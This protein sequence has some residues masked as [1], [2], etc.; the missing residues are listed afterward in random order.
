MRVTLALAAVACAASAAHLDARDVVRAKTRT[1]RAPWRG[2]D[3][4]A[5][6][7]VLNGHLKQMFPRT[8]P[9]HE[10]SA[11]EL[12]EFQAQLY[13]TRHE[14]LDGIYS[15]V[16]DNRR[17]RLPSLESYRQTWR[18]L[19][20]EVKRQP[21]LRDMHRD[22]HCHEAVMWL[23]HHVP[24]AEQQTRFARLEVPL[25]SEKRHGCAEGELCRAYEGQISCADCHSGT[26]I[27]AQ[28]WSD[29]PGVIPEDPKHPG[30]ARQ[31]RCDQNYQPVC[32]PCEGV[33]GPYWGDD[34]ASFQPTNC[35]VV[36]L[37][38]DVP[39]SE[40]QSPQFAESF[41]VHQLGSD[42]L[43]RTQNK[44]KFALYSQI[45]STLWYDFPLGDGTGTG[46]EGMAKLRH[47]TFYDDLGYRWLD[48]GLVSEL[49]F[50]SRAQRAANVTGPMVSMIH[51]LLGWGKFMG[52]LTC[53]ADPVGVPVLGGT[54]DV[55]KVPHSAFLEGADY[56][57]RI[58]IG[59][60]YAGF[61]LG[62]KGHGDM[63]KK[64]N[65]TVDHYLK[66]FLHIFVDADKTSPTFGQPVRFY[67]P[68]SG[69]AVYVSFNKTAPPEAVWEYACPENGWGETEHKALHPCKGKK[70]TDYP[71]M[72]VE[73]KHPEVCKKYAQPGLSDV[74]VMADRM[75]GSFGSFPEQLNT[76]LVV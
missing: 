26:G 35:E 25:L 23:V 17:L 4:G 30:W 32:S 7:E 48:D 27:I 38:E 40:R 12:Q 69:F 18:K 71:C 21:H 14:H 33:G 58:K 55:L 37:P 20:A 39:A 53:L 70:I 13:A 9:C 51:G 72:V 64:R 75:Q 50:Q 16:S 45:R 8:R 1:P 46:S 6:S 59:V 57:G 62:D 24:A 76:D 11:P 19:D 63:T 66:W 29:I 42:R 56:K 3:F 44:A 61:Q 54:V 43:V 28:D 60:E 49:H 52:G 36:A 67:G 5:M 41:T 74:E 22:G 47:D 73:K 2:G 65:M 68:Y 10:W 34:V 15:N 31:R